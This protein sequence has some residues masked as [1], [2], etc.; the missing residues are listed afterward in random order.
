MW[1]GGEKN[2]VTRHNRLKCGRVKAQ[3]E[4]NNNKKQGTRPTPSAKG[5]SEFTDAH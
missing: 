1:V 3:S 4:K 2:R 5:C